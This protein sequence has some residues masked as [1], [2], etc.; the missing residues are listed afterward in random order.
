MSIPPTA[1]RNNP[2]QG[3]I[4]WLNKLS[5]K[6]Q[7]DT[8]FMAQTSEDVRGKIVEAL[9]LD[10]IGP[11]NSH[12]FAR[13]LLPDSPSKWYLTGYIIPTN[14]PVEQ[15]TVD[16]SNEEIES[17][18]SEANDASTPDRAASRNYLPSSLGLTVLVPEGVKTL[19]VSVE[20]GDYA[21][22]SIRK[23]AKSLFGKEFEALSEIEKQKVYREVIKASGRSS[24]KFNVKIPRWRLLGKGC[25]LFTIGISVY[26]IWS[27]IALSDLFLDK[28]LQ[29]YDFTAIADVLIKTGLS[30]D[31]IQRLYKNDVAF[32]LHGNLKAIAGAWTGFDENWLVTK[33]INRRR[34]R[35]TSRIVRIVDS[36][37]SSARASSA[38]QEL[39]ILLSTIKNQLAATT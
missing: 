23:Y 31:G 26:N 3:F 15:R 4:Y 34:L 22:E 33:I 28:E 18:E 25:L 36:I 21:E 12:A 16:T 19:D 39:D 17:G 13:E 32:H 9:C 24:P 7:W 10:L 1:G 30:I 20:W 27:A 6:K 14:A 35:S 8:R 38:K 5:H 2:A 37:L 11:Y 29:S